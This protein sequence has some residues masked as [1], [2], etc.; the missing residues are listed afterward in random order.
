MHRVHRPS[1]APR[2]EG[3]WRVEVLL[4]VFLTSTKMEVSGQLHVRGLTDPNA[5]IVIF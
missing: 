5:A 3:V 4:Q 1:Y 2:Y